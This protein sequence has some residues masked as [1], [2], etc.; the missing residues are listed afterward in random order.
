MRNEIAEIS[1]NDA[2]WNTLKS[3]IYPGASD[4]SITMVIDYC[5]A[6][7]L[8]PMTKPVHIVPMGGKDVIMPGIGFQRI[9]AARSGLYA[10]MTE[11]EYGPTIKGEFSGYDNKPVFVE[12]PEWCRIS[13]KRIVGDKIV[14]FTAKEYWR[15]N[16]AT[17]GKTSAPNSM[18]AK[19]PFG[20]LAKCAEAQALRK[21]FPDLLGA[22]PTS[23]EM[24]G[25]S[26]EFREDTNTT[27]TVSHPI[28][29]MQYQ[30]APAEVDE[31]YKI[32]NQFIT[33]LELNDLIE[34]KIDGILSPLGLISYEAWKDTNKPSIARFCRKH[35]EVCAKFSTMVND[36]KAE[37]EAVE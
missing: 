29:D 10:G 16:Y 28:D 22:Q 15:E 1:K 24:E 8:D 17:A 33:D 31:M 36:K 18:W 11:P 2:V 12:Y 35:P 3:S 30:K 21:A 5:R 20:Q 32:D 13:V 14:E 37:L 9:V 34:A 19:R 27:K 7:K 25:K 4:S 23:D 26:F 6:A